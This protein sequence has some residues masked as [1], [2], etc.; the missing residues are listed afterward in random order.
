MTCTT[1]PFTRPTTPAA[2]CLHLIRLQ[3]LTS[4]SELVQA[5]G[6]SQPTV[7]RAIAALTEAGLVN[8]RTDLTRSTGRGRPTIPLELAEPDP[9]Y[10][11]IAV[12]TDFTYVAVFDLRGRTLRC[13]D[14]E[15]P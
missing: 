5:T 2:K 9:I 10:G 13:V 4:R 8:E 1:L 15:L 7:T 3:D 6:L 14:L 12:G 11:G